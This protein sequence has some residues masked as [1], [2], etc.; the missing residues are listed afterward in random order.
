MGLYGKFVQTKLENLEYFIRNKA[1]F[2]DTILNKIGMEE[3]VTC[4][5]CQDADEGFLHLF[6]YCNELKDFNERCKSIILTLRAERDENLEW[7]QVLMLGVNRECNNEKLINLLVMLMKSAIWKRR[8]VA[9]K[10]KSF[11][12][13]VE[14][15]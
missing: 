10:G 2:T 7:E 9:K 1:V 12:R 8:V 13:C 3:S 4:K 6:L 11:I 14:C 5:V 15:V